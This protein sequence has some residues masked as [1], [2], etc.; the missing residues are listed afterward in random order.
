MKLTIEILDTN[1]VVI[2]RKSDEYPGIVFVSSVSHSKENEITI[3]GYRPE[4]KK[5]G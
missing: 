1:G 4:T 3:T 2:E 5:E